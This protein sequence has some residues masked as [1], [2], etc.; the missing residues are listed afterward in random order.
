MV[1]MK[2]KILFPIGMFYPTSIG[3]PSN[4]VYWHTC[5]LTRNNVENYI[6]T[7]DCKLDINKHNIPLD[8]WIKNEAGQIIYC[9]TKFQFFPVYA[10]YQT[11]KHIFKVDLIHYSSAYHYLT[12]Y[13]ILFSLL[14][15]KKIVLSPRGE[16]FENAID[17]FAKRIV[18]KF[19]SLFQ[20][21]LLFHATSKEENEEI[22]KLFPRA[23]VVIQPNFIQM[24]TTTKT[25]IKSRNIVFLGIIYG[26]KK[27]ENILDALA[28]SKQFNLGNNKFLIAGKPLVKRDF[29]YKI[30]LE[31][32]IEDLNLADKVEFVGEIFGKEKEMFL[33]EAY[34]LML[35]SESENFG[36]VVVE[37][38]SQS[39][40]V[41][42]SKGTPWSILKEYD[43]GWW[44]S[45]DPLSL[46]QTIDEALL[47]SQEEY[48]EKCRNSL[49]L[50]NRKFDINLSIENQW[51]KIYEDLKLLQTN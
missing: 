5:F 39:T 3:G 15:K 41:I 16:F 2:I 30:M 11:L 45:N 12:I 34:V 4:T 21:K 46:S 27:I 13:T 51:I 32:K 26:V 23:K 43:A 10:W 49:N 1:I 36:N 28:I 18:L 33:N 20:Y 42:A 22:L 50:V 40:P 48:L 38:L 8:T 47:L 14:L 25:V 24:N 7:T 6:V 29:A 37:S 44:V 17:S 35:P 19:Y 31:K 9:K